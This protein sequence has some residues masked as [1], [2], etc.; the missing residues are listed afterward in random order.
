MPKYAKTT[1]VPKED[2]MQRKIRL[3]QLVAT[4]EKAKKTLGL[5]DVNKKH[6][7]KGVL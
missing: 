2:A 7:W 3:E 6:K 5:E 1:A 4:A